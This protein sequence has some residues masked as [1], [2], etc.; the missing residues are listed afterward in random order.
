[1]MEL[2]MAPVPAL[3]RSHPDGTSKNI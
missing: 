2:S 3:A 1:M